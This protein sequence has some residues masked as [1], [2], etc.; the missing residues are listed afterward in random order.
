MGKKFAIVDIFAGPGGLGEGFSRAGLDDDFE[1]QIKLSVE[2]EKNAVK[3]LRL[4]AFLRLFGKKFPQEYYDALNSATEFPDWHNL[5]PEM[6]AQAEA[7]V[8]Q[9]TLGE[10]GVFDHISPKLDKLRDDMAGNSILIGGPPCQAYSLV[11]RARNKG[12]AKYIPEEDQRHYLYK[13]YIKI[14]ARL[15][16]AA[17]VMENVKG[18]LSSKVNG[19][20]I[21]ELVLSDLTSAGEG[22]RLFPLTVPMQP[23][24]HDI[25]SRDF[26]I[27][28]ENHGIPQARHRVIIV[29]IRSDLATN[30]KNYSTPLLE[31]NDDVV[32]IE[33]VISDLP[34]LRSGLS[35]KDDVNAWLNTVRL[36]ATNLLKDYA[37]PD[38]MK[39]IL[40]D[41]VNSNASPTFRESS[42]K[43][44]SGITNGELAEWL[45]DD[46]LHSIVHHQTR[47]HIA[48]DLGRYLFSSVYAASLKRT[49]KLLEFPEFLQPRHENRTSG[50]FAD[51]FRT[52]IYG[53][54][55]TTIT[56]HISKDGHYF[57][58][59]DYKQC[60]SLTAREAARIQTFPDN[61]F[62]FGGRTAQY[63]QIGNAVPPLLAFKIAKIVRKLLS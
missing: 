47:G 7:E 16:P 20:D 8:L 6:W 9:L 11:G 44:N 38:S 25:V 10:A 13:E 22:Y 56:S 24:N 48:D 43:T 33:D 2:M 29:G 5:Y 18:I 15:S 31:A 3:T 36:H 32:P 21:F 54:P 53:R 19:G 34:E 45:E 12:N 27:K 61:Y 51:R 49:P 4:R 59:P 58:H 39:E 60:R 26:L 41:F 37:T 42:T 28:S 55:A 30:I 35:K 46:R 52:Q 62:F 40:E 14:L 1:M 57:I 63:H 17:F 50:H 23:E